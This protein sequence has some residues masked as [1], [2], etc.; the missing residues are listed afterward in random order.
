[1]RASVFSSR[2]E[3][4]KQLS[5]DEAFRQ[6]LD[7]AGRRLKQTLYQGATVLICGNGGSAAQAQHMAAELVG[8]L[9]VERNSLPAMALTSD[10]AT[11]TAV[12]NDYGYETVFSRQVMAYHKTAKML[13]LLTT[14]GKSE[15][16]LRAAEQAKIYGMSTLGLLGRDGG[17]LK[18]LCEISLV[19]PSWET[20]EI[21]EVHLALIHIL[22]S[23]VDGDIP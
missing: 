8:R 15:N 22:C 11:L 3:L 6:L 18:E 9:I 21:Q 20:A 23:M 14:S 5:M 2:L 10:S 7:E 17:R 1:M 12:A 16:L 19:V 4:F 13:I